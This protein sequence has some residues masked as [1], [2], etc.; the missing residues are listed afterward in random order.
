MLAT[1]GDLPISDARAWS[2]EVKWDGMRALATVSTGGFRLT[3]RTGNDVTGR[4]PEVSSAVP[5]GL[6]AGSV[7]DGE[8][9]LFDAAGRP[10]FGLLAPRIQRNPTEAVHRP[11]TYLVFDIL[12]L[13]STD[14][15]D[16]PY[17]ER[18]RLLE[19]TV[20]VSPRVVVPPAF[21]DGA[22]LFASTVEQGLEGVIAKRRTSRYVPG[23][24]SSEWIKVPHRLTRSYVVGGWKSRT[25]SPA[26]LASLLVGSPTA[27]GM[28]RYDGAVG[29]GLSEAELAAV[30]GVLREIEVEA[31]P[32][33]AY[34]AP[35]AGRDHVLHA[36][37]PVL[38]VDVEHLGRT[39]NSL[40]RQ[41]TI[42][43]LRPD[44]SPDDVE[45][46]AES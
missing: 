32:F 34:P 4:F 33:H 28:L 20:E 40:L 17:D 24:R 39:S 25:D 44:L 6:P 8:I 7:L 43:R 37:Q 13:G 26:R 5:P 19:D 45:R 41:P 14:V 10:S 42:A 1:P 15:M 21:D 35:E 38:V 18:R 12:R 16:R 9:V 11:V 27:D 2:Y 3:S 31:S 22:A 36:A 30:H 46:G 29:S 23:A